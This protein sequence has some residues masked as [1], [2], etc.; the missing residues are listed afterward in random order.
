M[1]KVLSFRAD[2]GSSV[3]MGLVKSARKQRDKNVTEV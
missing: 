3:E 2:E 1:R